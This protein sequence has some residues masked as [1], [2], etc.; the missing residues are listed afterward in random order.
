LDLIKIHKD[1]LYVEITE[2]ENDESNEY[3]PVHFELLSNIAKID[4]DN[5]LIK[6]TTQYKEKEV[7]FD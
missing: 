6:D 1:E 4:E 2:K 3:G 5:C 7:P